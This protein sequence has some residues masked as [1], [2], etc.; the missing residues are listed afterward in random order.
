MRILVIDDDSDIREILSV[1]LA[2]E[3]YEVASAVDGVAALA[4]LQRNGRPSL[5]L[6]DMMMPRLLDGEGF[7]KALRSEPGMA[8]IPVVVLTAHPGA[9][10]KADELGAAGC[11]LKPVELAELLAT[12]DRARRDPASRQ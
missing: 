9:R 12:V 5:I 1:V 7:M 3:G 10:T 11:L 6:L 4:E 8:D 2:S